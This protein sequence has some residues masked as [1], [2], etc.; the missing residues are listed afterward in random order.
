MAQVSRGRPDR[1]SNL[2]RYGNLFSL[3]SFLWTSYNV[4]AIYLLV[5]MSTSTY[6]S[7][8]RQ[9]VV[10]FLRMQLYLVPTSLSIK[11]TK[12]CLFVI[13]IIRLQSTNINF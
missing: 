2:H 1:T 9:D 8:R 13:T 3:I 11:Q 10:F 7:K 6:F 12:K 4:I 5:V